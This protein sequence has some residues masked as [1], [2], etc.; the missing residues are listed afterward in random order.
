M[1]MN[2]FF[3]ER[4]LFFYKFLTQGTRIAS[5]WPSSKA[6]AEKMCK[7]VN[8]EVPQTIIELGAGTGAVTKVALE[9]MHP[10][11]SLIVMESDPE[12][13][14]FLSKYQTKAKIL[15]CDVLDIAEQLDKVNVKNFDVMIS[16]LPLVNLPHAVEVEVLKYFK[17]SA[18]NDQ[19]PFSQ[20]TEIPWFYLKTYRSLFEKVEFE[21]VL[22]NIPPAGVYHCWKLQQ[23]FENYLPN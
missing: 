18:K 17:N 13:A 12:L 15:V 2:D 16:S 11:S 23:D 7:Y 9:K 10:E 19:V 14:S 8:P 20:L 1:L 3:K 21:F 4:K 22:L 6:L 5:V